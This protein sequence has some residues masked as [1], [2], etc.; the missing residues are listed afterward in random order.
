[1]SRPTTALRTCPSCLRDAL[2]SQF[3]LAVAGD[4][5]IERL[6]FGVPAA[7]C[8]TCGWLMIDDQLERLF[9]IAASQVIQAIET[10][11]ILL[12]GVRGLDAA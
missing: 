11:R 8:G 1:M 4:D 3:D 5:G 6:F 10:D 9:S 2:I 7:V 12:E